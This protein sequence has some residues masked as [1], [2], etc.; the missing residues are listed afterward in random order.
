M[1]CPIFSERSVAV[2][3]GGTNPNLIETVAGHA[4]LKWFEYAVGGKG[5][6]TIRVV[7]EN[8]VLFWAIDS[9]ETAIEFALRPKWC[10]EGPFVRFSLCEVRERFLH[11]SVSG[12]K[13]FFQEE[14]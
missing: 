7:I 2:D 3:R 9:V 8:H 6:L 5:G 4:V 14:P 12:L 1:E 10:G 11:T 13:V